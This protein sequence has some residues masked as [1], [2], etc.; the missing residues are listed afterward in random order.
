MKENTFS[1][2]KIKIA[3]ILITMFLNFLGFSIIFPIVPFMVQ[4]YVADPN[5]VAFY[6]GLLLSAYALCQFFAAP[7]LG[8]LS[9][10]YGRKPIL[11]ISLLGSVV[12]FLLLGIG[13]A[14][15]VL[16]LGRIID[17]LTGGNIST[18]YAYMADITEPKERGK[19]FG[20]LGAAG[21]VGIV[22][23]PIIGG[24]TSIINLSVPL[25][26][27]A[28]I[29]FL[30]LIFGYFI[31]TESIASEHKT[32]KIS[33]V[34]L[35]PFK[36][37]RKVFSIKI[38]KRLFLVGFLYF[39]AINAM[40]GSNGVFLKDVFS[41]SPVQIGILFFIVGLVDIF[42]QG[43]LV[44]RLLHKFSNAN[45]VIIGMAITFVGFVITASTAI[46][47]S[48]ALIYLGIIILNIGD[49]V[50]E[51]STN[52]LISTSV[53]PK[54]QGQVQ[55]ANQGM[56][57]VARIVGPLLAAWAYQYWRG[58]PYAIG[59]VLMVMSF[60]VIYYSVAIIKNHKIEPVA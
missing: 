19:Y 59:A 26:I 14:L 32:E 37:F 16:F 58:T 24:F 57:S 9:D 23:G 4:R 60:I 38:L 10:R 8:A 30:D 55:G 33:I 31:L 35:N 48:S 22:F 56:Q 12:G 39:I 40:Y 45:V 27:A 28:A 5:S 47:V 46:F 25:Y 42:S 51:P 3:F 2:H 29:T 52:S 41:W 44:R 53:G 18:I 7:G 50:F 43:F 1:P 17:G 15:W 6:V 13:G 20:L 11:L 54:S 49:G 21:G 34:Q 36:Q